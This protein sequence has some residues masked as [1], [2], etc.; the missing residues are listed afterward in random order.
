MPGAELGANLWIS[1]YLTPHD[2]YAHGITA[3]HAFKRTEFQEMAIVES[4]SYGKALVLDGKWQSSM[5]DEFLY[6][7]PLVHVPAIYHGRPK[8]VL[9]L[10]GAEGATLREVLKW[11]SVQRAVMVDLDGE[12]VEACKQYLPEMAGGSFDDPRGELIIGDA[13]QYLK[14]TDQAW[15]LIISDLTDPLEHGPAFRLFTKEYFQLCRSALAEGGTFTVQAG[16]IAPA[17]IE[18]HARVSRTVSEAFPYAASY[19]SFVPTY[20]S[21]HGY[22]VASMN[23]I[24]VPPDARAVDQ[25]LAKEGVSPLRMLDGQAMAGLMGLPRNVRDEIARQTTPY[26][27]DDPARYFGKSMADTSAQ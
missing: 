8:N 11:S 6:H 22:V 9:I 19:Q 7:E 18:L 25:L 20:G 23:P 14:E 26:T 17:E 24:D 21:P 27:L 2:V 4:P 15:D 12:V 13:E 5:G 10:G 3:V 1:E 16:A